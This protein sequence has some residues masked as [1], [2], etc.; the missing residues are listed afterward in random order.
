MALP[1]DNRGEVNLFTPLPVEFSERLDR[2]EVDWSRIRAEVEEDRLAPMLPQLPRL[3]IGVAQLEIGSV[4]SGLR[5]AQM[6]RAFGIVRDMANME[7][8]VVVVHRR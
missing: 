6:P 8:A 2:A 5:A 4:G 7:M 3:S 1:H